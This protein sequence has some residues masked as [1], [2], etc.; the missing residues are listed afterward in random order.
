MALSTETISLE[1]FPEGRKRPKNLPLNLRLHR[2]PEAEME[3]A[4]AEKRK[5]LG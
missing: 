3:R 2:K 4:Y 5:A 1:E